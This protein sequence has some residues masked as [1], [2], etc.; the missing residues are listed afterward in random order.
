MQYPYFS[1]AVR[2]YGYC[3]ALTE[4]LLF[5]LKSFCIQRIKISSLLVF[6]IKRIHIAAGRITAYF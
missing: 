5:L 4:Y 1:G 3:S 2:N 6:P